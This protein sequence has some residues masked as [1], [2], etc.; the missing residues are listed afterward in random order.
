MPGEP[1]KRK[2]LQLLYA[3]GLPFLQACGPTYTP[4]EDAKWEGAITVSLAR[5]CGIADFVAD[6]RGQERFDL[7][8][9]PMPSMDPQ[10]TSKVIDLI[11][12]DGASLSVNN[13]VDKDVYF[14]S[15]FR[16]TGDSAWK[17]YVSTLNR[18]ASRFEERCGADKIE[19]YTN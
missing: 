8:A 4:I 9:P 15:L 14:V 11:S 6:F 5:G 3:I 18:V 12:E 7:H 19:M 13:I 17:R 16:G 2:W 10:A 1:L